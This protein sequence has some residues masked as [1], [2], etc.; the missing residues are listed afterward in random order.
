MDMAFFT[1][2]N[3]WLAGLCLAVTALLMAV[4]LGGMAAKPEPISLSGQRVLVFS[5]TVGFRHD[6]IGKG[7]ETLS[8]LA[9][10]EGFTVIFS[11]DAKVFHDAALA[12]FDAVIFLNTTGDVLEADQ[13]KAFETYIRAGHGVLGIHSA[14]DTEGDGKWPWFTTLIGGH[15]KHHPEIQE[16]E[17]QITD[18]KDAAI[19]FNPDLKGK[20]SF[21]FTDEWY[22][23]RDANAAVHAIISID[24]ESY[25][26]S[27]DTGFDP[28]VWS[29]RHDGGKAFFI[30]LGHRKETYDT[31]LMQHLIL[32]GLRFVVKD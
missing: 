13:Q 21:R 10:Q 8:A 3:R 29:N 17:L 4:F 28:M 6:S 1:R 24:R 25:K 19:V 16:A 20:A 11:E 31:P 12:G 15:F 22:D 14:T 32:D 2:P 18:P 7:Q 23:F 30:G 9:K 27:Q 5:K 26:G